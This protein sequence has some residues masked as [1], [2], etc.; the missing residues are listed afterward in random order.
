MSTPWIS[1]DLASTEVRGR[2]YNQLGDGRR[3]LPDDLRASLDGS[4]VVMRLELQGTY[5]RVVEASA[6]WPVDRIDAPPETD[7]PGASGFVWLSPSAAAR[8]LLVTLNLLDAFTIERC[9]IG[10]GISSAHGT[11]VAAGRRPTVAPCS[12]VHVW[13]PRGAAAPELDTPAP[14][15]VHALPDGA[16]TWRDVD[17]RDVR[18]R[19]LHTEA[20]RAAA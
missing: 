19:F 5:A 14:V 7:P 6:L 17:P 15:H 1:A 18:A 13:L 9:L 8:P 11:H 12:S 10:P 20:G 16:G 4:R 3:A 2:I